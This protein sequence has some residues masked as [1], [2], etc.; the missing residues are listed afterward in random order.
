MLGSIIHDGAVVKRQISL[1]MII[2]TKGSRSMIILNRLVAQ[3]LNIKPT[4]STREYNLS[5]PL[6]CMY[7]VLLQLDIGFLSYKKFVMTK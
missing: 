4:P 3:G 6:L 5:S 7:I 1:E 2:R